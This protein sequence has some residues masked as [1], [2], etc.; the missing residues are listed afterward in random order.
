MFSAIISLAFLV[1]DATAVTPT[2]DN[3]CPYEVLQT[4]GSYYL[5]VYNGSCFHFAVYQWRTYG[6]ADA[7]CYS[8]GGTL[9]LPKTQTINDFLTEKLLN[10]YGK[11]EEA[12]IGL[13]DKNDE[14]G[15]E[16]ED[17]THVTWDNFAPGNGPDNG[18]LASKR[19]DCVAIDPM[20][21]G[22]WHDFQCEE[23]MIT[24]L[25]GSDPYKMYICQY[26]S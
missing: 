15:F 16:W 11:S 6:E 26:T 18:W 13:H 12:W 20:D 2:I 8:T 1:I 3:T 5:Q 4:V 22:K 17:H 25:S 9:A 14:G 23:D 7:E 24:V 19:E 10:F 21:D